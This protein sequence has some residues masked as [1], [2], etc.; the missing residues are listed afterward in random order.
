MYILKALICIRNID[1]YQMA[2]CGFIG[3]RLQLINSSLCPVTYPENLT[4]QSPSAEEYLM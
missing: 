2:V 3:L 4:A 1:E